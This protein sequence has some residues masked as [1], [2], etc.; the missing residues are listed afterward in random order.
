M[1]L[2]IG[3]MLGYAVTVGIRKLAGSYIEIPKKSEAEKWAEWYDPPIDSSDS[4]DDTDSEVY[5]CSTDPYDETWDME[6]RSNPFIW[7]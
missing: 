1:A 5:S 2:L 6:Y 4:S 3:W 7:G